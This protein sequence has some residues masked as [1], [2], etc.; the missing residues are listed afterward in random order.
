[1]A[2]SLARFVPDWG[3]AAL[4]LEEQGEQ[5]RLR[6]DPQLA[7]DMLAVHL[8]GLRRDRQLARHFLAGVTA[9]HQPHHFQL[10]AGQGALHVPRHLLQAFL[11]GRG[12]ARF[13][14]LRLEGQALAHQRRDPG[15][16]QAEQ[17]DLLGAKDLA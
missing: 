11:P 6:L 17:G 4:R 14:G 7:V 9:E 2:L 10:A 5:L 1:M 8:H 15:L 16:H 3:A 12:R 13:A